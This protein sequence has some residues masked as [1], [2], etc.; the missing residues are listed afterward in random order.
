MC[1]TLG[2]PCFTPKTS[3]IE[4]L[5]SQ[6]FLAEKLCNPCLSE[7]SECAWNVLTK[8]LG[9]TLNSQLLNWVHIILS[10]CLYVETLE[11]FPLVN[12]ICMIHSLTH[13]ISGDNFSTAVGKGSWLTFSFLFIITVIFC[14]P[15]DAWFIYLLK[16]GYLLFVPPIGVCIFS[17]DSCQPAC[18]GRLIHVI[19]RLC[20][21]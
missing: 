5:G 3:R 18:A 21:D 9:G 16:T 7:L 19:V 20:W 17:K 15:C 6:D 4:E 2:H 14:Q 12:S 11:I 8:M 13:L 10:V 1:H